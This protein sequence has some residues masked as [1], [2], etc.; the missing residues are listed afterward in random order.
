VG[1][2]SKKRGLNSKDG[3]KEAP[4]KAC[5]NCGHVW[6]TRN[7]FIIDTEVNLVGY[8]SN[9]TDIE[10]GVFLF[11]HNVDKCGSTIA[12]QV[13]DFMDLYT[14]LKFSEPKIGTVECEKRC[15][16]YSDIER[17]NVDCKYAHIR[18]IMQFLRKAM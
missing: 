8:Q 1:V 15:L 10:K 5:P 2:L 14:G 12:L 6:Q 16:E 18:E 11:N 3:R 4:F 17:C 7:D 13:R 9:I